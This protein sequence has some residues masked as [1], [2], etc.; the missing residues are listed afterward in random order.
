LEA[1][2]ARLDE[3]LRLARPAY[4]QRLLPGASEQ[5]LSRLE[6]RTGATLPAA[7]KALY[8]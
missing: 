3:L 5:E 7:F 2:I 1:L 4:H 8:R 6:Q